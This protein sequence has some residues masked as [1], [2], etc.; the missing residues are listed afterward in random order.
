MRSP[1]FFHLAT[2]L[3]CCRLSFANRLSGLSFRLPLS[4]IQLPLLGHTARVR[5]SAFGS[6]GR[7]SPKSRRLLF[8]QFSFWNSPAQVRFLCL[9]SL[10]I[11]SSSSVPR[12]PNESTPHGGWGGEIDIQTRTLVFLQPPSPPVP[13]SLSPFTSF[14][15]SVLQDCFSCSCS[16]LFLRLRFRLLFRSILFPS[17]TMPPRPPLPSN[18]LSSS[19]LPFPFLSLTSLLPDRRSTFA[20]LISLPLGS[21]VDDSSPF[22]P[23]PLS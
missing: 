3:R 8:P 9:R 17:P 6:G 4:H 19:A 15:L 16:L 5:A 14:P 10:Q 2:F 22:V 23:S 18:G 12:K 20:S 21:N 7:P 11:S 1:G 13:P